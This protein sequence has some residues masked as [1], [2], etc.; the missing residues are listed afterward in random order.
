MSIF[1]KKLS[2]R[3]NR[4]E[5]CGVLRFWRVYDPYHTVLCILVVDF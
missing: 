3:L 5:I 2:F 1:Y 4:V